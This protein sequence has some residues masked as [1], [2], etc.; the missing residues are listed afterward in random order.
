MADKFLEYEDNN[1]K[2]SDCNQ[3]AVAVLTVYGFQR[4]SVSKLKKSKLTCSQ[5]KDKQGKLHTP[6]LT[7][8]RLAESIQEHRSFKSEIFDLPP[9]ALGWLDDTISL[10]GNT[11]GFKMSSNLVYG[12][13]FPIKPTITGPGAVVGTF[14]GIIQR[15]IVRLHRHLVEESQNGADFH[16]EWFNQFRI[17]INEVISVVEITLHQT[18]YM[19]KYRGQQLGWKFNEKDLGPTIARS[20]QD[21]LGWIH[22]ITGNHINAGPLMEDFNNLKDI[23]NHLNHFDPPC[24]AYEVED[25]VIWLNKVS[26][27]GHLLLKIREAINHPI[28]FGIIEIICLPQVKANPKLQ[29]PKNFHDLSGYASSIWPGVQKC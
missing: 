1:V 29:T 18:Y 14:Q 4:M 12:A 21:K 26:K 9:M 15:N 17:L 27:V 3:L 5:W 16:H 28:S 2:I 8:V 23:R 20:I 10:G 24:F 6:S 11:T 25:M 7:F 13:D 19:A 22:K